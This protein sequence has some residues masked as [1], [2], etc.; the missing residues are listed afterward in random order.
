MSKISSLMF[1]C[2]RTIMQYFHPHSS[3]ESRTLDPTDPLCSA[4][5]RVYVR[6]R[7]P[8]RRRRFW[9]DWLLDGACF[10]ETGHRAYHLA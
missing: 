3:R 5:A 4:L 9:L 2:V 1:R 10:S 7:L 8:S 6:P